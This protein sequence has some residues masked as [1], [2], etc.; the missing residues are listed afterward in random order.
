MSTRR[1]GTRRGG[2]GALACLA[3][4]LALCLGLTGCL[5]R[6]YALVEP[7]ENRY[8][9]STT[10]DI[11]RAESYQDL[12]N[13]ILLLVEQHMAEG[14]VRLYL[15]DV[16]HA[17]AFSMVKDAC[18]EVRQET[19]LGS[20]LLD[21]LDFDMEELR[22]SYYEV[23]LLPAYRRTAEDLASIVETASSSAIYELLVSA[24]EQ[25]DGRLTVRYAYLAEEGET[26]VANIRQLQ[27]ELEGGVLPQDTG[28]GEAPEDP[29]GETAPPEEGA[30]GETPGEEAPSLVPWE[31]LFY[32]PEGESSIV[33]IFLTPQGAPAQP[34]PGETP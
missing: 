4:A 24:F 12:V 23:T 27:S 20:Y 9:E 11:L 33:E 18:R 2:P 31:I 19:A 7:H 26:L 34:A 15:S 14:T 29:G 3:A 17:T 16:S 25:G 28:G 22:N 21:A 32:P 10:D 1:L 13:T 30:P 6:E 8:W 5:D